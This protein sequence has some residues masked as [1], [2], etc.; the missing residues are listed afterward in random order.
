MTTGQDYQQQAY[1]KALHE[2][3]LL[4]M[5]RINI[6][7][8]L[9][10]IIERACEIFK[11]PHGFIY[12]VEPEV[13]ELVLKVG[14]G[15]YQS[16]LGIH[17]KKDAFS[18]SSE[19][20]KTGKPLTIVDYQEWDGR[21]RDRN[22]ERDAIQAIIGLPLKSGSQ[23]VGVL[24]VGFREKKKRFSQGEI[25]VMERFA[26]LASIALDNAKLYQA[27]QEEL[28]ERKRV[29]AAL[30]ESEI[31]YRG[32]F[33]SVND[34]IFV[35]DEQTAGIVDINQKVIDLFGFQCCK[36]DCIGDVAAELT[37]FL[38]NI[39]PQILSAPTIHRYMME[40][41]PPGQQRPL[42]LEISA[43]KAMI[44]SSA[45]I[46]VVARDVTDRKKIEE[47][48]EFQAYHDALTGI[49]NR[50][51]LEKHLDLLISKM[52]KGPAA[53]AVVFIDLNGFKQVNDW[54]GHN[55]GDDVLKR[56]AAKMGNCVGKNEMIARMGGDEFVVVLQDVK[57]M[58]SLTAQLM[59]L[60]EACRCSVGIAGQMVTVTASMGVSLYPE[61]GQSA[62]ALIKKADKAMYLCKK[63]VGGSY[64][65]ASQCVR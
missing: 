46:L 6:N 28:E 36:E 51:M 63:T 50:C 29:E 40:W 27:L 54:F 8:L 22:L 7:D 19:V 53:I 11:T 24:G 1:L 52:G 15:T 9:E 17:R 59:L 61:D 60:N 65:L 42:W 13:D 16:Y 32:I 26:D 12:L 23:V 44:G 14:I 3:A 43:R 55:V 47:Q 20:W 25:Y 39:V 30:R 58:E 34:L 49:P 41:Q 45:R 31:N 35:I 62:V 57:N 33:D 37:N 56:V 38:D 5:N 21:A 18:A 2:T 64:C 48:L 10:T 4:L